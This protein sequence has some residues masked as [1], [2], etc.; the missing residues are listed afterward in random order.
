[1]PVKNNLSESLS[2]SL[3]QLQVMPTASGHAMLLSE[4]EFPIYHL[5]ITRFLTQFQPK[6]QAESELVQRLADNYWRM[7]R[8]ARLELGLYARGRL[9]FAGLHPEQDPHVRSL[10][11]EAEVHLAYA[12]QLNQLSVQEARLRRYIDSDLA[13]LRNLQ[14]ER[15]EREGEKRTLT[16]SA[17]ASSTRKVNATAPLSERKTEFEFLDA[18]PADTSRSH[19]NRPASADTKVTRH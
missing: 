18:S 11:I 3:P 7:D 8:I 2:S 13:A 9:E 6:D 16:A 10:L 5:H 19:P 17:A 1:M 14:A 12:R 4:E 15:S